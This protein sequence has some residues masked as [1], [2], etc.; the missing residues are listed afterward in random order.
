MTDLGVG[1]L[2]MNLSL[3]VTADGGAAAGICSEGS[4]VAMDSVTLSRLMEEV[5]NSPVEPTAYNRT[6]NRH[7]RT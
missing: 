2:E 1:T 4:V 5:R 3:D 6:H 7:N